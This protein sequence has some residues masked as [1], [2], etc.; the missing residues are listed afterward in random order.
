MGSII[1]GKLGDS[2][3]RRKVTIMVIILGGVVSLLTALSPNMYMF[4]LC[5]FAIGFIQAG[6]MPFYVLTSEIIGPSHRGFLSVGTS[7]VFALGFVLVSV[8][9]YFIG[10]WRS[11]AV[12]GALLFLPFIAMYR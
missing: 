6:T 12:V 4:A 5:R 11:L 9:A 8:C 3:G 1:F 10:E 7:F 2:I